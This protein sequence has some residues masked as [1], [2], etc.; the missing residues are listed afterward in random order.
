MPVKGKIVT[1]FGPYK[2]KELNVMNYRNGIDIA[3]EK[4]EPIKAVLAGNVIFASWFKGYGN[5]II[6]DHGNRYYTV[7]AHADEIFKQRGQN[8][9]TEEVIAIV[10]DTGSLLGHKL[11]FEIRH[12]D[13]PV[14]P[15][16]WLRVRK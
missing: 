10:G 14:D 3:A 7:Y 5:M 4:G 9:K 11:Y 2:N 13:K 8:V 12:Q 1:K 16:K 15:M 6:L